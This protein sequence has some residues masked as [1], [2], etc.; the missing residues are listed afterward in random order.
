MIADGEGKFLRL[1]E[2]PF[3]EGEMPTMEAFCQ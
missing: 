1:G 3:P 2:N